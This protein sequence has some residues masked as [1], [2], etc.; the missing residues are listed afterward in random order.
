MERE[1]L[2]IEAGDCW[3]LCII[4]ALAC[5]ARSWFV[6]CRYLGIAHSVEAAFVII[7][8]PG[9][10]SSLLSLDRSID[11]GIL[12]T[13]PGGMTSHNVHI[14]VGCLQITDPFITVCSFPNIQ[15]WQGGQQGNLLLELWR[16][17]KCGVAKARYDC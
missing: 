8:V 9:E 16:R 3:R 15:S 4:V 5:L 10:I 7:Q 2:G 12:R 11:C 14:Q 1:G 13:I 17:E 6:V